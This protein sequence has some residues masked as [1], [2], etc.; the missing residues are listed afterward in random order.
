MNQEFTRLLKVAQ[1][2]GFVGEDLKNFVLEKQ[3][4]AKAERDAEM[5]AAKA[6]RESKVKLRELDIA[7]EKQ[8]RELDIAAEKLR[9]ETDKQKQAADMADKIKLKELELAVEKQKTEAN[10]RIKLKEIEVETNKVTKELELANQKYLAEQQI[11]SRT[12]ELDAINKKLSEEYSADEKKKS[13]ERE[14]QRHKE[15]L[16]AQIKMKEME[17]RAA[18]E[19]RVRPSDSNSEVNNG[20]LSGNIKFLKMPTF[21]ENIDCLDTYLLRFERMCT[22]YDIP[23]NQWALVLV[24]SLEGKALEVY[25][26]LDESESLN[27]AKLKDAL[28]RRFKLSEGGYR[29]KFKQCTRETDESVENY[30]VRLQRYLKQWLLMSGLDDSQ[31]GLA[32]LI[33]KDQFYVKS[34]EDMRRFLKE[35]GKLSLGEMVEQA[36]N[37]IE[38]REFENKRWKPDNKKFKAKENRIPQ[39][40]TEVKKVDT[41]GG[42]HNQ[43]KSNG[44]TK[45]K[46]WFKNKWDFK[47]LKKD[48]GNTEQKYSGCYRCGSKL[49][50]L[51]NCD[52]PAPANKTQTIAAIMTVDEEFIQGIQVLNEENEKHNESIKTAIPNEG[53][54][55]EMMINSKPGICLYDSGATC[56]A[57]KEGFVKPNMYTGDKLTC[58]M[59]NGSKG[60]YPVA[61]VELNGKAYKGKIKAIV[62]PNL[63]VD[64]IIGPG[65]Y[66]ITKPKVIKKCCEVAVQTDD[67][68][69]MPQ[70]SLNE[71]DLLNVMKTEEVIAVCETRSHTE[72][73]KHRLPKKL[74]FNKLPE[75]DISP[76]ELIQLQKDDSTL[77]KLWKLVESGTEK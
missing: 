44:F 16:D 4:E 61:S 57:V 41:S 65:L 51:K 53:F 29:L 68:E 37:F 43:N 24:R 25:Q 72:E 70:M 11:I 38:S 8:K 10:E 7:A 32:E 31:S 21:K 50:V 13:G 14:M 12:L 45:D 46:S 66:D 15:T 6:E 27:Y 42:F 47:N 20:R 19:N 74:K 73:T 30:V 33:I 64:V 2:L 62:M 18:Q 55:S 71:N 56:N 9:Q 58:R 23:D 48:S 40:E 39:K 52:A 59:A 76:V 63:M 36:Q 75:V 60:V 35:K 67:I 26:N 5:A 34:D 69:I 28:L 17:I 3:K 49:H 77:S 1:E 54:R 22:A